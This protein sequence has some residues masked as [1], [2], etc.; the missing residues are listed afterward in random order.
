MSKPFFFCP[1]CGGNPTEKD[2]LFDV[3]TVSIVTECEICRFAWIETYE[4]MSNREID[5]NRFLDDEGNP[6]EDEG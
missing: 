6:E 5:G 3:D 2:T 1:K 4:F